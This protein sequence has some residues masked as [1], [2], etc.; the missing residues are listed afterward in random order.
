MFFFFAFLE[1]NR[2]VVS[3]A[4]YRSHGD[5]IV[6]PIAIMILPFPAI[7]LDWTSNSY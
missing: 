2:D 3:A 7:R 1:F 4:L 6:L 5:G